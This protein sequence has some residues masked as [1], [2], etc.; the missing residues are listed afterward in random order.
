[1]SR[2]LLRLEHGADG[3]ISGQFEPLIVFPAA[4]E[5]RIGL[6]RW[7]HLA[8]GSFASSSSQWSQLL[9]S[10]NHGSRLHC[11]RASIESRP[12]PAPGPVTKLTF[13]K[14]KQRLA[15][16]WPLGEA[17][18]SAD[19]VS[20]GLWRPVANLVRLAEGRSLTTGD[21][22]EIDSSRA[23]VIVSRPWALLAL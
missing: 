13:R 14:D 20:V 6:A 11:N 4:L 22:R 18:K 7:V 23:G 21:R 10:I 19:I 15:A 8:R 17:R 5:H 16:G 9:G 12:G 2:F 1:M 3:P